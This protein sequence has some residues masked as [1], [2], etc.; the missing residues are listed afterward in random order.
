MSDQVPRRSCDTMPDVHTATRVRSNPEAACFV[1]HRELPVPWAYILTPMELHEFR[2]FHSHCTSALQIDYFCPFL[3]GREGFWTHCHCHTFQGRVRS[4][5]CRAA[6]ARARYFLKGFMEGAGYNAMFPFYRNMVNRGVPCHVRY[7][8]SVFFR[9]F[10]YIYIHF[11]N[12]ADLNYC[13]QQVSYGDCMVSASLMAYYLVLRCRSC[14]HLSDIAAKCCARHTRRLMRKTI[15]AIEKRRQKKL[16]KCRSEK[17]RQRLLN[18]LIFSKQAI[19]MHDFNRQCGLNSPY[20]S[21][22]R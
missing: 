17:R 7:V 15:L 9:Q 10:H 13:V 22:L 14:V 21:P 1:A 4:L 3:T 8:G 20:A 2:L 11:L 12:L 6:A 18:K 16:S 19:H 5:Q